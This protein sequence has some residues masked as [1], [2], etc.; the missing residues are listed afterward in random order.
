MV[1]AALAERAALDELEP[2]RRKLGYTVVREP[3]PMPPLQ[4]N[5]RMRIALG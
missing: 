1:F 2:R 5:I 4:P 3:S